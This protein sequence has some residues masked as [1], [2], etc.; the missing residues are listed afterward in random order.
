MSNENNTK[1][2]NALVFCL[3]SRPKLYFIFQCTF[4]S[5]TYSIVFH[6]FKQVMNDKLHN[7]LKKRH[8]GRVHKST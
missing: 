6:I 5:V 7:C 4:F 1:N 2:K 3:I 8:G